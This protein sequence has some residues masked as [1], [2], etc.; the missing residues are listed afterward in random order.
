MT[1]AKLTL[2]AGDASAEIAPGVGGAVA[3]FRWRGH[4]IMRPTPATAYEHD[5]V[6]Q[7]AS[8]PLVPFSNRVA[9]AQLLVDTR[10]H[11]LARNFGDHPHAIHGVGWQHRWQVE[12]HASD[13]ARIGFGHE[14]DVGSSSAWPFAF[15]ATQAFVLTPLSDGAVL[16]MTL[17]IRNT[18]ELAFPF[19]L[20]WHP[21]FARDAATTLGFTAS[22][23]WAT[24]AT[25]I[26]TEH[27]AVA[28]ANAFD[29]PR[30]IGATTLDNVFTGW[31]GV[32]TMRWPNR[33]LRVTIE[34]DRSCAHLVVYIPSDRDYFAIEPVTHMTDAFNRAARG[35]RDTGTRRLAPGASRCV[36]MRIIATAD[37]EFE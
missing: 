9:N 14:D 18:S 5:D 37:R 32:A 20:G 3:S 16:T 24:D 12:M 27:H 17:A 23:M 22:G 10:M 7:F 30:A 15:H 25:C 29:P 28:S 35:E 2:A 19:G 4:D 11:A 36:T 1:F 6:R 34:A 33:K 21:F 8:Y 31:D 13:S 26:P